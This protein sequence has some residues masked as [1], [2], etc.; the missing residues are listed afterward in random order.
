MRG[1]DRLGYHG[2]VCR[3]PFIT[4]SPVEAH[5]P[6]EPRATKRHVKALPGPAMKLIFYALGPHA[7]IPQPSPPTRQWMDETHKAFA[8]RCLPLNIANSHGWEILSPV[9]FSARWKGGDSIADVDIRCAALPNLQ[10]TSVFGHGVLTFHLHGIFRTEPG[11]NIFAMG[12]PNRP[13]DGI[14]PLSGIIE[15]DW[16]PYT[17]TM[18]WRFTRA[19]QWISFDEGEPFCFVFPVPRGAL[20]GIK[21]ELRSISDD[22]KLEAEYKAWA[23]SRANFSDQ[24]KIAVSAEKEEGWQKRYYR[25]LNMQDE[26]GAKDHQ[27]K[28]RLNEFTDLRAKTSEAAAS[29]RAP[30]PTL[31]AFFRSVTKLSRIAHGKLGLTHEEFGFASKAHLIPLTAGELKAVANDY[32]IVFSVNNPPRPLAVVGLRPGINLFVEPS[33]RWRE[34]CYVPAAVRRYPFI[35]MINRE[36][37]NSLIVGIDETDERLSPSAPTKLFDNGERTAFC[38]ERLEFCSRVGAAFEQTD[39]FVAMMPH[40][41][42]LM[43]CRN[44][45]N[46]RAA[47]RSCMSGLRVIDPER[48]AALP[49]E[50]RAKWSASGWL[51]ALEAQIAS[52]RNWNRLLEIEDAA[53]I[54]AS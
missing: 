26:V 33:G 31:P 40:E 32:P 34:G 2:V 6:A 43:P 19:N 7:D 17:F 45:A 12:P 14:Y 29:A 44:V 20:N 28:L 11:W 39:K 21:P 41:T 18:N 38:Q 1:T 5:D 48:L 49:E 22:P 37:P 9:S 3:R 15:T 52:A 36:D 8:Y 46:P 25:G 4:L 10:P 54:A 13:K 30:A 53:L 23:A 47:G 24:L 16:A 27:A 42:L 35:T 50:T 51:A